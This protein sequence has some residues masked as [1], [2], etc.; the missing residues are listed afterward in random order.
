ME[1]AQL[2]EQV[3]KDVVKLLLKQKGVYDDAV[4]EAEALKQT[5]KVNEAAKEEI[6]QKLKEK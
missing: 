5:K 3:H 1:A 4:L 6:K 2:A